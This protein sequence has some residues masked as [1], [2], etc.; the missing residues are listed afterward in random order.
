MIKE[1][2]ES[3][4]LLDNQMANEVIHRTITYS[5]NSDKSISLSGTTTQLSYCIIMGDGA[6]TNALA[7]YSTPIF[8]AGDTIVCSV[9]STGNVDTA[10]NLNARYTDSSYSGFFY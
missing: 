3:K 2:Q 8:K 6:P 7:D 5:K 10:E 9:T 4:N 1:F